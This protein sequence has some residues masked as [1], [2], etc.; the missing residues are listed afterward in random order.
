VENVI[1]CFQNEGWVKLESSG[2][3]DAYLKQLKKLSGNDFIQDFHFPEILAFPPNTNFHHHL[4]YKN[5]SIILQSKVKYFT[6][7][8]SSIT[9]ASLPEVSIMVDSKQLVK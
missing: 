7:S 1:E 4:L 8:I 3:Y 5:Y 2:S 6:F 9:Q